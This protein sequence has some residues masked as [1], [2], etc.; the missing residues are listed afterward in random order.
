MSTKIELILPIDALMTNIH[1]A[2][3]AARSTQQLLF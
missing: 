3:N 2:R 1:H